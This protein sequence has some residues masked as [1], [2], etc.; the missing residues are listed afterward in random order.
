MKE[1]VLWGVIVILM[2][3]YIH[4]ILY[5]NK[6]NNGQRYLAELVNSMKLEN[7]KLKLQIEQNNTEKASLLTENEQFKEALRGDVG[8]VI[9][10][11]LREIQALKEE[12]RQLRKAN[13]DIEC[14][15]S[16]YM[17]DKK[18]ITF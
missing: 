7:E 9:E 2:V 17:L 18:C 11:N 13:V 5:F 4:L 1:I 10:R 6:K 3:G 14:D 8:Y 16:L 15:Y 12:I